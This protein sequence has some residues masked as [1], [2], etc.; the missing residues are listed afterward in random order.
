MNDRM[1]PPPIPAMAPETNESL[2][3]SMIDQESESRAISDSLKTLWV[4]IGSQFLISF[5]LSL[6]LGFFMGFFLSVFLPYT[7]DSIYEV[8]TNVVLLGATAASAIAAIAYGRKAFGIQIE[9]TEFSPVKN[10]MDY[11]RKTCMCYSLTVPLLVLVSG[12]SL[13]LELL[14]GLYIPEAGNVN[15]SIG[16]ESVYFITAV[17]A[18]PILEEIVF[19]GLIF[20]ALKKYSLSF[21]MFFS[22]LCFGLLH[23]NL[24]QGIPVFAMGILL[25]YFYHQ[26]NTLCLP[27]GIHMINNLISVLASASLGAISTV[28]SFAP[29]VLCLIGFYFLS[30]EWSSIRSCFENSVPAKPLWNITAHKVSFWLLV[31]L[32]GI[33]SIVVILF[34]GTI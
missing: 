15:Y 14:F 13:V 2:T 29:I 4:Y 34:P 12:I 7:G 30:Q 10:W 19:R 31:A 9:K 32:F 11:I 25:A 27:I 33:M 16:G 6:V 17:I 8:T 18:A 20:K 21:A 5:A 26:S 23:M 28:L 1:G 24:F 3:R 22:A